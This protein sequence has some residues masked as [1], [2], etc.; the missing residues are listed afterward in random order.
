MKENRHLKKQPSAHM[1]SVQFNSKLFKGPTHNSV[2]LGHLTSVKGSRLILILSG[3][4]PIFSVSLTSVSAYARPRPSPGRIPRR[5]LRIT[6]RLAEELFLDL[7]FSLC[8]FCGTVDLIQELF[9]SAR[10]R[11]LSLKRLVRRGVL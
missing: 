4:D 5:I 7:L 1:G 6:G 10:C 11:N 3:T 2:I 9:L 8:L